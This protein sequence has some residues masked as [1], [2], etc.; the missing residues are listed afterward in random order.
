[1]SLVLEANLVFS[2]AFPDC[3]IATR[4]RPDGGLLL[5]LCKGERLV[6]QRAMALGQFG[7]P[8]QLEWQISAIR[9]ELAL[10]SGVGDHAA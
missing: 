8:L 10:E 2:A 6:T 1:M 9:R 5:T 7:S 3:D 4:I